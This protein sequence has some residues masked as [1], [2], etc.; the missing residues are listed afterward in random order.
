[1]IGTSNGAGD[2]LAEARQC[3]RANNRACR[4][5]QLQFGEHVAA[6]APCRN[7]NRQRARSGTRCATIGE[8]AGAPQVVVIDV[9][10]GLRLGHRAVRT[11]QYAGE[12]E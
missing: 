3:R 12:L 2:R 1:M 8:G 5:S 6:T 9:S 4:V 7:D 11:H 10:G